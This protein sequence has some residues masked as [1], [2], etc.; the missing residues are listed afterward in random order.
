MRPVW[1]SHACMRSHKKYEIAQETGR[2]RAISHFSCD[3]TIASVPHQSAHSSSRLCSPSILTQFVCYAQSTKDVIGASSGIRD[4]EILRF[5]HTETSRSQ[6]F[7]TPRT[8]DPK[9]PRTR[10]PKTP[11]S[12]GQLGYSTRR[13]RRTKRPGSPS[14]S[15][16][17]R[18]TISK[19]INSD[20]SPSAT[21]PCFS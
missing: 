16:L 1:N 21:N 12:K 14:E 8:Q 7:K 3:L 2:S 19:P 5:Q 15:H 4:T 17:T 9:N 11:R 6:Y 10:E 20:A 18:R 13:A